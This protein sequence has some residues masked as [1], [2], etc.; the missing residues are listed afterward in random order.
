MRGKEARKA[1]PNLVLV[2]VPCANKKSNINLY[3]E[4][5]A[6]VVTVLSRFSTACERSSIDEVRLDSFTCVT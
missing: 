2:Q 6:E 3:R 1:C 4:A 5:G